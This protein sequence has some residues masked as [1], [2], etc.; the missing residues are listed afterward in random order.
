MYVADESK[1]SAK[2]ENTLK[3][4][5]PPDMNTAMRKIAVYL[6]YNALNDFLLIDLG[7]QQSF[8]SISPLIP[9]KYVFLF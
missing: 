9:A 7:A 1:N 3:T 6:M 2:A 5:A 4:A 8:N